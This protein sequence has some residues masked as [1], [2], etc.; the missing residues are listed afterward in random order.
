MQPLNGAGILLLSFCK[1][2]IISLLIVVN[3]IVV[4]INLITVDNIGRTVD[5]VVGIPTLSL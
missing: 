3:H 2:I 1:E 4:I 5:I